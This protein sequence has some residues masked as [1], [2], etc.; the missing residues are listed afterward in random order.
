MW[1]AYFAVANADETAALVTRLGG[2]VMGSVDDSPFG[3]IA[4]LTDPSGAVFKIV[5]PPTG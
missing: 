1:I 3:R 5:Q 2:K 4:A